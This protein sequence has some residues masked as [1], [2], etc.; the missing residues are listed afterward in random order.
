MAG[1]NSVLC[2]CTNLYSFENNLQRL[3][4]WLER[5]EVRLST[6]LPESKHAEQEKTSLERVEAFYEEVLKERSDITT[7]EEFLHICFT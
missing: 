2:A 7:I 4:R 3:T 6:E 5:M 1:V